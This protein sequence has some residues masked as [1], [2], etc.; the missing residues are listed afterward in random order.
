MGDTGAGVDAETLTHIFDPFVNTREKG[1]GV[2]LAAVYGIVKQTGGHINAYSEPGHGTTFKIYFSV[3]P[4]PSESTEAPARRSATPADEATILIVEDQEGIR[5]LLAEKPHAKIEDKHRDD[6]AGPSKKEQERPCKVG[7]ESPDEVSWGV[8]R[9]RG[10]KRK[11]VRRK[12]DQAGQN[13]E[14]G[15]NQYNG[16]DLIYSSFFHFRYLS[17]T[18]LFSLLFA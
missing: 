1:K 16:L 15:G 2:G 8:I 17:S 12:R 9:M 5:D 6:V 7:A 11:I 10:V 18:R 3:A 4:V 13:D 14:A